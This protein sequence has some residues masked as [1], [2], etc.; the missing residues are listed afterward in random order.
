MLIECQHCGAPLDVRPK[1]KLT[2]CKYCGT[3]SRVQSLK[4]VAQETPAGW[5]PPKQWTPPAHAKADSAKTLVYHATWAVR[6]VV[7]LVVALTTAGVLVPVVLLAVS[8]YQSYQAQAQARGADV[9]DTLAAARAAIDQ[10]KAQIE[11]ATQGLAATG[12]SF[13]GPAGPDRAVEQFRQALG[14]GKILARR[15]V[16]YPSHA[17]LTAQ[18]PKRP[19]HLDTYTLRGSVVGEPE[20]YRLTVEKGRL[21]AYLV[22][23]DEVSFDKIPGLVESTVQELGYEAASVS[24][25]IIERNLPFSKKTVIRVYASGPRDSGRIDYGARGEVLKVYR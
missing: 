1:D 18:D 13:L 5:R 17:L 6:R 25:V 12:P 7:S 4:T 21:D 10:A 14:G 2:K 9:R 23:L 15:L 16:L 11:T 8:A 3:T 22:D 19:D 24:H 20:A